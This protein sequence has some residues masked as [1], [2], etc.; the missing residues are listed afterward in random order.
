MVFV[1]CCK[2][3]DLPAAIV[4][5][6]VVLKRHQHFKH[7]TPLVYFFR[8]DPLLFAEFIRFGECNCFGTAIASIQLRKLHI[9]MTRMTPFTV[10]TLE[11]QG[12][13]KAAIVIDGSYYLLE[14][15]HPLLQ[16]A[17]S[18]TLLAT[19]DT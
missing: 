5:R 16:P 19:W 6:W 11:V 18:K 3:I 4:S 2:H 10:A 14:D 9:G 12:H 1:S 13:S 15:I 17:S 7:T 8:D